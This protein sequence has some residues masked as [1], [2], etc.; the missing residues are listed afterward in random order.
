[1]SAFFDWQQLFVHADTKALTECKVSLFAV[2]TNESSAGL[3]VKVL[4]RFVHLNH[5]E[6]DLVPNLEQGS[7]QRL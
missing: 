5:Y 2:S 7:S 6:P 3:F 4:I 1:M